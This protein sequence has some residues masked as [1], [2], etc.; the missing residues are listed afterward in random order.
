MNELGIFCTAR[1]QDISPF[2][3]SNRKIQNTLENKFFVT[4]LPIQFWS[5]DKLASQI[6]FTFSEQTERTFGINPV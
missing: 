3:K 6:I 1:N 4:F 2:H 5:R